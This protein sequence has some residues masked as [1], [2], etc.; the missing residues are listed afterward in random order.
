MKNTELYILGLVILLIL[1]ALGVLFV[2][3]RKLN[4][5]TNQINK[6]TYEISAMQSIME[7]HFNGNTFVDAQPIHRTPPMEMNI[8]GQFKHQSSLYPETEGYDSN[9]GNIIND[10][11]QDIVKETIQDDIHDAIQD[12]GEMT[13]YDSVAS[14]TS[15]YDGE[16]SVVE[17]EEDDY[18][19]YKGKDKNEDQE[20]SEVQ[21]E[22]NEQ[23]QKV[24]KPK[25]SKKIPN[26][27]AKDH[28]DGYEVDSE[29]DGQRYRVYTAKNGAKRWK[30]LTT[31]DEMSSKTIEIDDNENTLE[32]ETKDSCE[33]VDE[34]GDDN[35][36]RDRDGEE[37]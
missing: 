27:N 11:I 5:L 15:D 17:I 9:L 20:H 26:D 3:N 1:I 4:K 2:H 16:D 22:Y 28:D 32:D 36:D 31:I 23:E 14:E 34:D 37:L 19:E 7:N 24:N 30:R 12:D 6:N 8:G 18:S 10:N 29:N 25:K 21:G 35:R 33:E 13:D